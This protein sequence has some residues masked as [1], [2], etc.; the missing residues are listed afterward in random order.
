[1]KRLVIENKQGLSAVITTLII[2]LLVIVAVGIVWV[3][4]K[5]TIDESVGGIASGTKCLANT[6]EATRL[7]TVGTGI[8]DVVVE[9]VS[10][11]ENLGGVRL[12]FTNATGDSNYVHTEAGDIAQLS[13]KKIE[14]ID[15]GIANVNKVEVHSYFVDESG[16]ETT[17]ETGPI[18]EF[19]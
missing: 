5:G 1:M 3:V 13:T 8:Y 2:I 14:A 12:I 7:I 18:K 15:T 16:G 10:G 17:C 11:N 6:V 19:N 4:V 9:R